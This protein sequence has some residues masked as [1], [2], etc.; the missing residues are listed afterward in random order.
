ARV[1]GTRVTVEIMEIQDVDHRTLPMRIQDPG[2]ATL[3]LI[4]RDLEAALAHVNEAKLQIVTPNQK[5]VALAGGAHAVLIRD[6]DDRF[7]EI[8]QPANAEGTSAGNIIEHR[9]SIA[10]A[11]LD[12]TTRLYRDALGFTVET[13]TATEAGTRALTGLSKA[14]IRSARAQAPGSMLWI[15]FVEY[16]G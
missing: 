12:R 5:P 14:K 13:A 16:S 7:I 6:L 1:A 8:R 15:E 11:D 4:V 10:V 9:L 2:M 3:V